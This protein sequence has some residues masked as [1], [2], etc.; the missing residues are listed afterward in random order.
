[1]GQNPPRMSEKVL[2]VPLS[3]LVENEDNPRKLFGNLTEFAKT[4]KG[5]ILQ[6]LV[7]VE[8]P[9]GQIRIVIGHRR[10]RG[11]KLAGLKEVPLILRDYTRQQALEAMIQEN[12]HRE[13]VNPMELADSLATMRHDFNLTLDQ[14]AERVKLPRTKVHD[15]VSLH[16]N[17][18]EATK[19]A[20]L[21]GKLSEQSGVWLARVRGER[22][23]NAALADALKLAKDGEQPSVRA[24]KQLVQTRY[25]DKHRGV[26]KRSRRRHEAA[27]EQAAEVALRRKV[28]ERLLV[29]VGELVE[30]KHHLDETDLRTMAIAAAE[31]EPDA[32][33]TAAVLERRGLSGGAS[34][35]GR[36]G[37]TQLR[38]LV[39]ELALAPFVQLVDGEYSDGMKAV[40]K[41]Y[42]VSLSEL[43]RAVTASEQAE[44]LFAR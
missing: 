18:F 28:V 31:S 11:G 21:G 14:V 25:L 24:V 42:G 9:D 44:A 13:D 15:L 29:R 37:A 43:E 17:L 12:A 34:K 26:S 5:G 6:P 22:L 19:Q 4:L 41:A 38:S 2:Q 39:V 23:Q 33:A 20:L 30:R 35:V 3:R 27:A 16:D 1:M 10:Y 40:A 32:E 8:Q 36:L 7:G